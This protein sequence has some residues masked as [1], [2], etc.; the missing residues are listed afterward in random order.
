MDGGSQVDLISPK[1]VNK[2]RIPWRIKK[3]HHVI[4][5]PF[6]T[7]WVRRETEPLDITVEGKTTKVVFDIV[8]MGSKKDMILGRPWHRDYD[9]DISWKGGG[10][11]R[12]RQGEV[13]DRLDGKRRRRITNERSTM[14]VTSKD[15]PHETG[16]CQAEHSGLR[17]RR[18]SPERRTLQRLGQCKEKHPRVGQTLP[19]E[20]GSARQRTT[21]SIRSGSRPRGQDQQK[22]DRQRH[23][24]NTPK[25]DTEVAIIAID[26]HRNLEF[27]EWVT[28]TEAASITAG[29]K[30]SYY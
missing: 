18:Q 25:N 19:Q 14:E 3:Q 6:D 27:Q 28:W 30:F 22:H 23:R 1:L 15:P 10:H 4:K 21:D 9:P 24:N 11:L 8:D 16:R 20:T 7:Q 29:N 5:G 2:L 26:E 17:K 13:S 12:P